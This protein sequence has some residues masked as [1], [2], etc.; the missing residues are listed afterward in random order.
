VQIQLILL[1]FFKKHP[2]H[3]LKKKK[4]KSSH[5]TAGIK[6]TF[7]EKT[8][9]IFTSN[10]ILGEVRSQSKHPT[11]AL[12]LAGHLLQECLAPRGC[13]YSTLMYQPAA[14]I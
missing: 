3:F 8:S 12:A 5:D 7:L 2:P 9:R 10:S 1:I 4:K 6:R 13:C 11:L 14:C